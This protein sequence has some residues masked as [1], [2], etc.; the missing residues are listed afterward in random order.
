[1][2]KKF[3]IN[4]SNLHNGGGVQVA[5][6]VIYELSLL[7]ALAGELDVVVSDEVHS[8]LLGVRCN[9]QLFARYVIFNTYGLSSLWSDFCVD[10]NGY[11]VV[12]TIFGPLYRMK[13]NAVNIVGFAQSWISVPNNEVYLILPILQK[14]KLK[15]KFFLQAFFFRQANRLIVELEHVKDALVNVGIAKSE[16]VDVVYNCLSSLYFCQD[17]WQS[18]SREI[19]TKRFSIGFVG[20][21]YIHKNTKI[22]PS[23]KRILMNEYGVDVDFYVT[24]NDEEWDVKSADFKESIINVGALDVTQCPSFYQ[25]MDAVIFPSLLECFSATPLEAMVMR[26]PLFA[27]DRRF[28]RDVCGDH[29][30]YFDPLS[31]ESAAEVIAYYLNSQSGNDQVFLDRAYNHVINFSTAKKRALDYVG[32]MKKALSRATAETA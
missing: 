31:P 7:P 2:D 8:A 14:I 16:D 18:L 3:L 6:S 27:S 20:R 9:S 19:Y 30:M 21:D 28:V 10:L 11:D 15:L 26:K 22:L 13:F 17:D 25:K 32:I 1:M 12:L 4:A 24:F 5:V 23:I 29:V